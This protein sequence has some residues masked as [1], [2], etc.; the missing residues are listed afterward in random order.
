MERRA[1][2][3]MQ[4]QLASHAPPA[5]IGAMRRPASRRS[6]LRPI[7]ITTALGAAVALFVAYGAETW[8]GLVPCALCLLERWP[9]RL[10]LVLALLAA[11]GRRGLSRL[12]LTLAVLCLLAGAAI[13]AVHVGV[14]WH[15][16]PSP[17][18]ECAA[19]RLGSGSIAERLAAMPAR[20]AKPCDDPTYLISWLPVS[21]AA[22]NLLY[23]LALSGFVVISVQER[24]HRQ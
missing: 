8:G 22:M 19:P 21:F 12:L 6:P 9:Y 11:F 15:L 17:L 5:H 3:A 10:V 2:T 14:E 16:W 20:P 1:L 4:G 24:L 13:A 18:P 7:A 23:A